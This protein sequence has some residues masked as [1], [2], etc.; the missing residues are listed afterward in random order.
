MKSAFL[1]D[2]FKEIKHT[3]NRFIAILAI[4]ALGVGFIAGLKATAPTM[5]NS[6]DLYFDSHNFMDVYF[7]S[8]FGFTQD[9]VAAL[10]KQ[11]NIEKVYATYTLDALFTREKGT[12]PIKI[13]AY[14]ENQSLNQ[15]ELL[16]GRMPS[17]A[18]ECVVDSRMTYSEDIAIGKTLSLSNE[19]TS[20][21]YDKIKT[22]DFTI[23]GIVDTP[24]YLSF[25]RG[26]TKL[27]N[28]SISG[29]IYITESNFAMDY[30]T[31]L[32]SSVSGAKELS[33][34]SDEYKNKI[35]GVCK[36][37]QTFA[38]DRENIRYN[39]I[40]SKAN[41]EISEAKEELS[42]K[43]A[44][45]ETSLN[46]AEQ[47]INDAQKKIN[48]GKNEIKNSEKQLADSKDELLNKKNAYEK[49][50]SDKSSELSAGQ[51][52]YDA[53]M[54]EYK[55]TTDEINKGEQ[56]LSSLWETIQSM[57][58]AG[59]IQQAEMLT[60]KY[61]SQ[62]TELEAGK[63]QAAQIKQQLD[64]AKKQLDDG[65]SALESAKLS[66]KQSFDEAENQI[67]KGE[68]KLM[69]SK[70]ELLSGEKT[71]D[72]NRKEFENKKSEI[73]KQISDAEKEI[74]D[75]EKK[76][77]DLARPEWYVLDRE[78]NVSYVSF[79]QD[80]DKVDAIAA[81]FPLF[82]LMVSAIVCLTTMTRMVEEQRTQ[83]GV[84][85]A[86]GYSKSSIAM[87]Y[88]VYAGLACLSG[89][90]VGLAVG[91]ILFPTVIMQAYKIM[92]LMP[93]FKLMPNM[94][95]TIAAPLVFLICISGATLWA[96]LGTLRTMPAGLIRP[97]SPPSGKKILLERISFFW[98]KLSFSKK[99]TARNIVRYKKRFFMTVIGIVGCTAL[100]VT[101]FGLHDSINGI[102]P[103]QFDEIFKYDI[104]VGLKDPDNSLTGSLTNQKVEKLLAENVFLK[105]SSIEASNGN[106]TLT[107]YLI[108]PENTEQLS[109]LVEFRDRKTHNKV[110]FT[111]DKTVITEKLASK[112]GVSVGDTFTVKYNDTTFIDVTV[113]GICENYIHNYIYMSPSV[114][115]AKTGELPEYKVI[116][117]KYASETV[118][119]S[120][121]SQSLL[122][123]ENVDT[124]SLFSETRST[125]SDV[126]KSLN[127]I[128]VL[129][130]IS[131]GCLAFV[132]LYNLVNIT[133]TERI[134]EIATIKVLG[135]SDKEVA[136]Y[137]FRENAI[138]SVIGT[139]IGLFAGVFLHK[140]VVVTA[141]VEIVMFWRNISPISF[142]YAA[143]VM[144]L[145]AAA[146]NLIMY[147]KLRKVSMVESLKSVE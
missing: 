30:Y 98:K 83:I 138:L 69:S 95:T 41:K 27:G 142:I 52:K 73:N 100:M 72:E 134:R 55:K 74:A 71:L 127:A 42:N 130:V 17:A 5:K 103:K 18:N 77:S 25:E 66:A 81:V 137:V 4:V 3:F 108:V 111:D 20:D 131:A 86:L 129:V 85:K 35:D 1:K 31:A 61:N 78:T 102:M 117:G 37:L 79:L 11:N 16:E 119:E 120:A 23:V 144:F 68:A 116:W 46:D 114:F 19:N 106:T 115:E 136:M 141:E 99:V 122:E 135:F 118:D 113:G 63:A 50:V 53:G 133:I 75:S 88:L 7:L 121:V 39:N 109:S 82:F 48:D 89:C 49:E 60:Q 54:A 105:Q 139:I 92:Y 2:I 107:S 125:F 14:S 6:A 28:G 143:L 110:S 65:Y 76:I 38:D 93:V 10:E 96:C 128:V 126:L 13:M 146:V 58:A 147:F 15:P 91:L 67:S 145:F 62:K 9:D 44:E 34:Y 29:F 97:K 70:A 32:Y 87:K 84:Y 24:Q 123:S 104:V 57:I 26:S 140:F 124:V 51:K 59:Q 64:A 94:F 47:K 40:V 8:T 43:K 80:T 90:V 101:G 56:A 132:V 12:T 22:S 21:V 45:A 36:E 33:T 112:L